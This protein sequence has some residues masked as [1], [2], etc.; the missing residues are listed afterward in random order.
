[1]P[2]CYTEA[3]QQFANHTSRMFLASDER[4]VRL[5]VYLPG[6][7]A[8]LEKCDAFVYVRCSQGPLL[9]PRQ[10]AHRSRFTQSV[11][12]RKAPLLA[13]ERG[14]GVNSSGALRRNVTAEQRD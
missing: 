4:E 2:R 12:K 1:M 11:L 14:R 6:A 9:L 7:D 5:S 13:A 3:K 8:G 10:C